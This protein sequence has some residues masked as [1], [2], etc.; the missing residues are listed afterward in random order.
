LLLC[1]KQHI[2]KF[3]DVP[4]NDIQVS[5]AIEDTIQ[6]FV[7]QNCSFETYSALQW[8]GHERLGCIK[9]NTDNSLSQ[10]KFK[11]FVAQGTKWFT[12]V[13]CDF[14]TKAKRSLQRHLNA[15]H[16]SDENAQWFECPSCTFKTKH[17]QLLNR[18]VLCKH[19]DPSNIRWFQCDQCPSKAKQNFLLKTHLRLKQSNENQCFECDKCGHK[20]KQK[21]KLKQS[22]IVNH[23][24][25]E[26]MKCMCCEKCSYQTVI[27]DNLRKH[28]LTHIA[29]EQVQWYRCDQ[30]FHETKDKRSLVN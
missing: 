7:C 18:H 4:E 30:C 27:K 29:P 5:Y 21:S 20:C 22:E 28:M 9:I 8:L 17:K 14:Q 11:T 23:T 25:C 13:Q 2:K 10:E 16:T 6:S 24:N 19:I 26:E 1:L 15:R 3:H 12:C